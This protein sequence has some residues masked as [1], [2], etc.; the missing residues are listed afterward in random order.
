MS[1]PNRGTPLA[2]GSH[3]GRC[4]HSLGGRGSHQQ[5]NGVMAPSDPGYGVDDDEVMEVGSFKSEYSTAS[6][7]TGTSIPPAM[8]HPPIEG[9]GSFIVYFEPR[10]F[11]KSPNNGV[12]PYQGQIITESA[13]FGILFHA[14]TPEGATREPMDYLQCAMVS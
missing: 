7:S 5:V 8:D 13:A 6:S 2:R 10:G 4:H 3:S 12:Y 9:Y 1:P 11:H 14:L